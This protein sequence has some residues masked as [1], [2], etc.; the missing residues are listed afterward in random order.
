MRQ[1]LGNER[2]E[3]QQTIYLQEAIQ[4][5]YQKFIVLPKLRRFSLQ[6]NSEFL[7]ETLKI[8][9]PVQENFP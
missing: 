9:K 6:D 8:M 1:T 4:F 3:A 2:T 5:I 7:F